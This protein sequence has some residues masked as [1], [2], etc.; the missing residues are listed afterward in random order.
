MLQELLIGSYS[1]LDNIYV[2]H[3][4]AVPDF[5]N[6][7]TCNQWLHLWNLPEKWRKLLR[8][9]IERILSSTSLVEFNLAMNCF[10][11][12]ARAAT[13]IPVSGR[14]VN[15]YMS[16]VA[17]IKHAD[18]SSGFRLFMPSAKASKRVPNSWLTR[19]DAI[20]LSQSSAA[21]SSSCWCQTKNKVSERIFGKQNPQSQN[22]GR[23]SKDFTGVISISGLKLLIWFTCTRLLELFSI[24]ARLRRTSLV[25]GFPEKSK[26]P[27][28]EIIVSA[29]ANW[30]TGKSVF[31]R[32]EIRVSIASSRYML[33]FLGS[34]YKMSWW[35]LS[36][37]YL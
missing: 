7:V 36:P 14:M 23:V 1:F 9:S 8:A 6:I 22:A 34:T 31:L 28:S 11:K 37:Y 18:R 30:V 35:K 24:P 21:F 13:C 10:S 29:A 19:T 5:W 25:R 3:Y 27:C 15:M 26:L 16:H 2:C 12:Q 20:L 4:L 17:D 33:I 32:H